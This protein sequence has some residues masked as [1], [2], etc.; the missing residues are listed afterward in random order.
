MNEKHERQWDFNLGP[1]ETFL[2]GYWIDLGSGMVRDANWE[3]IDWLVNNHLELVKRGDSLP[4]ALYRDPRDGRLWEK[5]H[6]SP[7]LKDGGPPQLQAI[8]AEEARE[9]YGDIV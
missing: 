1:E 4:D 2:A 8:T 6:H 7:Q 9:R 3:R 5:T